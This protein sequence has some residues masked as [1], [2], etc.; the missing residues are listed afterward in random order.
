LP[1]FVLT[2]LDKPNS[3]EVRMAAREAHIAYVRAN[4]PHVL[5]LGGPFLDAEGQMCGSL[6]IVEAADLDAAKAF[7]A[8]DPYTM[9]GLFQS[10]EIRPFRVV[11]GAL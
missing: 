7:N 8:A 6:L 4:H 3:L 1:L 11:T 9:A 2:C 5:K 10:V